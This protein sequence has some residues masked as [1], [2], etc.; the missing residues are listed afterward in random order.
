MDADKGFRQSGVFA[1]PPT[2]TWKGW[3]KLV[4]IDAFKPVKELVDTLACIAKNCVQ[5]RVNPSF[6]T[7]S[8][9]TNIKKFAE[10]N[11]TLK[12]SC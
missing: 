9:Q 8:M 7:A 2:E 5:M 6:D 10:S 4:S 3:E 1:P 12:D 11:K